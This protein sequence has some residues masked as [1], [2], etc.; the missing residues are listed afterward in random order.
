MTNGEKPIRIDDPRWMERP[1]TITATDPEEA[2]VE[3]VE[4]SPGFDDDLERVRRWVRSQPKGAIIT[5]DDIPDEARPAATDPA[6]GSSSV[7]WRK[8]ASCNWWERH[9]AAVKVGTTPWS[10]R[11]GSYECCSPDGERGGG[12]QPYR[13]GER[14]SP[15]ACW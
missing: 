11:G 1:P 10:E 13:N 7:G 3:N 4:A 6:A 8:K 14:L 2:W 9:A 15:H 5:A 12:P